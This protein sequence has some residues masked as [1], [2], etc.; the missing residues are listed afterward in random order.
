ML[1]CHNTFYS[2]LYGVEQIR[3]LQT[4]PLRGPIGYE[5]VK[6]ACFISVT[7]FDLQIIGLSKNYMLY[8]ADKHWFTNNCFEL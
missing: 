8:I 4:L 7:K 3:S 5:S 1:F 6:I 2:Y